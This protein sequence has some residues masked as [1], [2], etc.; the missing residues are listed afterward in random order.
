MVV[1]LANGKL[2]NIDATVDLTR[3]LYPKDFSK[4]V[5]VT[6]EEIRDTDFVDNNTYIFQRSA[7]LAKCLQ[8]DDLVRALLGFDSKV[9][10]DDSTNAEVQRAMKCVVTLS[11]VDKDL[12]RLAKLLEGRGVTMKWS[13]R[14]TVGNYKST[15]LAFSHSFIKAFYG[16][17]KGPDPFNTWW[18]VLFPS[19]F[20]ML[21]RKDFSGINNSVGH[22]LGQ[23]DNV[24]PTAWDDLVSG[25]SSETRTYLLEAIRTDLG[26]FTE[27][28]LSALMKDLLGKEE[29]VD[30]EGDNKE[31]TH[32]MTGPTNKVDVVKA[33][34]EEPITLARS[35][36]RSMGEDDVSAMKKI[37]DKY[38]AQ[39]IDAKVAGTKKGVR[40]SRG[41]RDPTARA[42]GT[43]TVE[44]EAIIRDMDE[45]VSEETISASLNWL[46][47]FAN[48]DVRKA[49]AQLLTA[50]FDAFA[51]EEDI[52]VEVNAEYYAESDD[53]DDDDGPPSVADN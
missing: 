23:A 32:F 7:L 45:A 46:R 41:N 16:L 17:V 21:V 11:P 50:R 25:Y 39:R 49:A 52:D 1:R 4:G 18:R 28:R 38:F 26:G 35:M 3:L 15:L 42:L 27:G 6:L 10:L 9:N 5:S 13:T 36:T 40:G 2:S 12:A 8:S 33:E 31:V 19:K 14:G 29:K 20:N 53:P 44:I 30:L 48:F 22:W 43:I 24:H 47:G 34:E 51:D 37:R